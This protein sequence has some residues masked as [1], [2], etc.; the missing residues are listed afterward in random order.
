MQTKQ[1]ASC[2]CDTPTASRSSGRPYSAQALRKHSAL[3]IATRGF[4]AACGRAHALEAPFSNSQSLEAAIQGS[5]SK[6]QTQDTAAHPAGKERSA[7]LLEAMSR[8]AVLARPH[9]SVPFQA[10][11]LK[12]LTLVR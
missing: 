9:I 11:R 1:K 12:Q 7:H 3:S 5:Q 4:K 6:R 10:A 8:L 2:C